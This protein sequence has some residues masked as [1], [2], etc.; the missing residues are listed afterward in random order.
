MGMYQ[1]FKLPA[2][3]KLCLQFE[4]LCLLWKQLCRVK[5]L[6]FLP[7][8]YTEF[9]SFMNGKSTANECRYYMCVYIIYICMDT[10]YIYKCICTGLL[11]SFLLDY[12]AAKC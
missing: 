5:D 9:S 2:I 8:L 7:L 12:K 3:S 4:R 10:T 6:I 1:L 11:K